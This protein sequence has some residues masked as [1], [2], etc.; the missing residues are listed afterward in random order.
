M[1]QRA[2]E[3]ISPGDWEA[4]PAAVRNVFLSL[5]IERNAFRERLERLEHVPEANDEQ[6]KLRLTRYQALVEQ[7]FLTGLTPEQQQEIERLGEE[8]DAINSNSHPSLDSLAEAIAAQTGKQP[9]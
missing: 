9:E 3:Q 6:H 5:E 7:Q 1:A 2:N 4:T 8:I